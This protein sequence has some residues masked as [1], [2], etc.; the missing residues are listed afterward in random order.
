[1]NRPCSRRGLLA[2]VVTTV[3]V[4][5]GGF[6]YT[7]S[8]S[9][10]PPLESGIVP[11]DRY[12]CQE[13]SRPEPEQA[14][15]NALQ[16]RTYPSP[17]SSLVP[18]AVQYVTAFERAYR[19]N[20]FLV[21]YG[22]AARTID[23]R[24]KDSRTAA[25]GSIANPDAVMVTIIYDL[26]TETGQ[27]AEPRDRWEIRVVYYVDENVVLRSQYHGIAEELRSEPDPRTHGELVACFE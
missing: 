20:A 3:A 9:T 4:T 18:G 15:T 16:P 6:E 27:S 19:Q 2:T 7:S 8:D 26:T 17:P 21:Q 14:E 24:R 5:T 13:V 23:L 11:A 1:M 10:P 12:D 25:I 22:S